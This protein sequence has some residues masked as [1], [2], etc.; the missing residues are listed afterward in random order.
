MLGTYT[1][2]AST[3][4]CVTPTLSNKRPAAYAG[5]ASTIPSASCAEPPVMAIRQRSPLRVRPAR[6]CAKRKTPASRWLSATTG[7]L[8]PAAK[9]RNP[10]ATSPLF[11]SMPSN[12]AARPSSMGASSLPV[13]IAVPRAR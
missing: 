13:H 2:S 10:A 9:L 1:T 8:I 5:S 3:R 7:W 12:V 11:A 6:P 4:A